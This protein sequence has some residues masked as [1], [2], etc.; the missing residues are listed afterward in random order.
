MDGLAALVLDALENFGKHAAPG[1][2]QV[3]VEHGDRFRAAGVAPAVRLRQQHDL[4]LGGRIGGARRG[5]AGQR[6]GEGAADAERPTHAGRTV[7]A[8]MLRELQ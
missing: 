6:Q 7:Q 2:A 3:G 1:F 5:Q 4:M 8:N